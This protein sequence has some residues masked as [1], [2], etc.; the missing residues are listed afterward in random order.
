[1]P[2]VLEGLVKAPGVREAAKHGDG[3]EGEALEAESIAVC[4]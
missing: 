3:G 2:K 4:L 1:M